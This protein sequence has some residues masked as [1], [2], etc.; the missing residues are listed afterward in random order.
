MSDPNLPPGYTE[1]DEITEKEQEEILAE[2][3]PEDFSG[4]SDELGY[5]PER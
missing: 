3:E 4:A 5:A 1:E 2:C